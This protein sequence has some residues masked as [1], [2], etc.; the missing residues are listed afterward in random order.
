MEHKKTR[1]LTP[2]R[3]P[4]PEV[5]RDWAKRRADVTVGDRGR[6]GEAI[7]IAYMQDLYRK[8]LR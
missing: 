5:I 7:E 6:L 1:P 3:L 2:L 8:T 4:K